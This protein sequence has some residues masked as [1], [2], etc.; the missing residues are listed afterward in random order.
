MGC[1]A[2]G[3][4]TG[5]AREE[6]GF[7][8]DAPENVAGFRGNWA[9]LCGDLRNLQWFNNVSY[10]N[11]GTWVPT[12]GKV[13]REAEHCVAVLRGAFAAKALEAIGAGDATVAGQALK[14]FTSFG[15]LLFHQ[16]VCVRV[17][18]NNGGTTA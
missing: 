6:E 8:E 2:E 16:P 13:P 15:C 14:L 17:A 5:L 9:P 18:K 1:F 4:A 7:L 11:F 10:D 3:A 12:Y